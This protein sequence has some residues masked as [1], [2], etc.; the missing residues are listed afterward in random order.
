M[1]G[2]GDCGSVRARA[3]FVLCRVVRKREKGERERNSGCIVLFT[4]I[5]LF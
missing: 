5:Y 3:V 2:G 4:Q 1:S